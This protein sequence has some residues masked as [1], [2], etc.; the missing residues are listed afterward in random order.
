MAERT[1]MDKT[2]DL[3]QNLAESAMNSANHA[4][5]MERIERIQNALTNSPHVGYIFD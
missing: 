2:V 1:V 4:D 5:T 3:V